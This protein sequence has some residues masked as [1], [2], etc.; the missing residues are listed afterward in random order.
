MD[1]PFDE[2]ILAATLSELPDPPRAGLA[3][4]GKMG[5]RAVQLNATQSDMRPRELDRSARRD[6]LGLVRRHELTLSGLDGVVPVAHLTDPAHQQRAV[7]FL[8]A[9]IDLA[10]DLDRCPLTV[11]LPPETPPAVVAELSERAERRG[12]LLAN[13]WPLDWRRA[14]PIGLGLD[15]AAWLAAGGDPVAA[16]CSQAEHLVS[17]RLVDLLRS[18]QRGPV[19][20]PE[21]GRLDVRLYRA[22]LHSAGYRSPVVVDA[23]R[24]P[25]PLAGLVQSLQVWEFGG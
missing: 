23:R 1:R 18:G 11:D 12:V 16:V 13:L 22:A 20:D 15:P 7:D 5:F 14:E 17:A 21:E 10:G 2:L 3:R 6:L 8:L 24:W 19:G 25:D 4:L 9:A